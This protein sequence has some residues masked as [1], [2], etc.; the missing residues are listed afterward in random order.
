MAGLVV[1]VVG[2]AAV[3][4]GGQV[5]ADHAVRLGVGGRRGRRRQRLQV[6]VVGAAAQ[7]T[8]NSGL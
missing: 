5:E 6:L 8:G 3:E 4:A 2:A 7:N 1:L